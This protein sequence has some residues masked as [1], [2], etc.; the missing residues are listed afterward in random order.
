MPADASYVLAPELAQR[1]R[2]VA[3]LEAKYE[4]WWGQSIL[5]SMRVC[6]RPN[7]PQP[8]SALKRHW[9]AVGSAAV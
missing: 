4:A 2:H 1:R 3:A 7:K 6:D 9:A 8:F 5:E